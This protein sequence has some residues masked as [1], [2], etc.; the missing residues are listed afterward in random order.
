MHDK[1]NQKKKGGGEMALTTKQEEFAR[2]IANGMTY[3]KAAEQAGYSE[4]TAYSTG[5]E[6][7]K[8]PEIVARIAELQEVKVSALR[9][10]FV[11]EAERAFNEM[12]RVMEDVDTPPQ[13]KANT[14]KMILDYAGF[15]PVDKQEIDAKVQTNKLEDILIQLKEE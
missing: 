5:S 6:N 9:R 10:R 7:M 15:K 14:A 4:K 13:T 12:I 2:N 11:G 1:M 8:K 3:T